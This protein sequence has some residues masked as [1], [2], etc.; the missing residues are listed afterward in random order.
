MNTEYEIF[1]VIETA[2]TAIDTANTLTWNICGQTYE[3]NF[4][5]IPTYSILN[6]LG[7]SDFRE[8]KK[9]IWLKNRYVLF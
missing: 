5:N 6:S 1:W 2:S 4:S 7:I 9:W 3:I 8:Q